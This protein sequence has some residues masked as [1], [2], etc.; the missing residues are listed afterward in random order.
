MSENLSTYIT[1]EEYSCNHCGSLP[2]DL[3]IHNI[4]PPYL[5]LFS[6]FDQ[7]RGEWGTPIPTS[8]GYRCPFHND[9]VGGSQISAHMFGLALDCDFADTAE[10]MEAYD[11]VLSLYPEL[12]IGR[13]TDTGTFV[14]IDMAYVVEPRASHAWVRAQRWYK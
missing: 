1:R 8:S 12:R 6:M 2:P 10:V 9:I 4:R 14:H 13:Y 7:I 11:L 3:F 5:T